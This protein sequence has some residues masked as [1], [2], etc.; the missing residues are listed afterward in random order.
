MA[1]SSLT[2]EPAGTEPDR[3]RAAERYGLGDLVVDAGAGVVRRGAETLSLSPLTFNLLLALVRHAPQVVRREELLA[4]VWP[5]EFVSDDT[6]SQ[7]VR[8]LREALGDVAEEPRYLASLRGWGYKLVAP[9]EPLADEAAPIRAL[10]VLPL[11]NLSGDPQQE[12]FADGMTETLILALAKIR[13]LKVISRTSVMRYKNTGRR[14]PQIGR[15]L[16]VDAV[17]EGT[18]LVAGGR[19][20]V[21]AQLIRAATDEHLWAESY[22]RELGDVL[23]LHA[24]LAKSIAHQVRAVVTPEERERLDNRRRVD[25]V[26]HEAELRGRYFLAKFTPADLERA[27]SHFEQAAARDPSF[28]EPHGGLANARLIRAVPLGTGL[29]TANA[30]EYLTHSKAAATRALELDDT[31]A[32]AHAALGATL[33]FYDWNWREA[34]LALDRA[35]ELDSNS[36]FTHSYRAVLASTRLDRP[37]TLREAACAVALDPLNLMVRAQM[38]ECCYWIR[39]HSQAV[40]YASQVLELDSSFPRAHFVLGRVFEWQTRIDE[41]ITEYERAG[42]LSEGKAEAARDALRRD[43]PAGYHRWALA[44]GLRG[45]GSPSAGWRPAPERALFRARCHSRLG[46]IDEAMGCL[47]RAYRERDCLLAMLKSMEWWDPL[48]SDAR[49]VDL[50]RRIGIP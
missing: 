21:S 50:M 46:E 24:D 22:D 1:E 26:A 31:L 29:S 41:A 27:I 4:T 6:L 39:D 44:A 42:M 34:E 43:G 3:G 12:Y 25:P 28:A 36:F 32:E 13:A 37:G 11:A 48:R 19:V 5:N 18:V 23:A 7:R 33:L 38:A 20:R 49:F 2:P 9:V 47:E 10:A 15:E 40:A 35:L 14:L 30:R 8:L 45:M 16:G 17:V